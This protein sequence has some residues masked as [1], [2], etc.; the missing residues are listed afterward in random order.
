M[1]SDG[2]AIDQDCRETVVRMSND[3]YGN[4]KPGLIKDVRE[5]KDALVGDLSSGSPGLVNEVK[6]IKASMDKQIAK[7]RNRMLWFR[8]FIYIVLFLLVVYQI[9]L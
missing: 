5:I 9:F 7:P 6:E 3:M 4:G 8:D 1:M 2:Q